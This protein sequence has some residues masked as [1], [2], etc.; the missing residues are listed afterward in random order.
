[1]LTHYPV[2]WR[3]K[4]HYFV[5]FS[6]LLGNVL[7]FV[8]GC[9]A[10]TSKNT[11]SADEMQVLHYIA[12]VFIFFLCL[13]WLFS[14]FRLKLNHPNFKD[15]LTTF[16]A[17]GLCMA[18]VFSNVYV[19][20]KTVVHQTARLV[21]VEQLEIDKIQIE[22]NAP[23]ET[24]ATLKRYGLDFAYNYAVNIDKKAL[25]LK[26]IKDIEEAHEYVYATGR[27]RD[28]YRTGDWG[29]LLLQLRRSAFYFLVIL[30]VFLFMSPYMSVRMFLSVAFCHLLLHFMSLI[31]SR[32]SHYDTDWYVYLYNLIFEG[33]FL[34]LVIG[35]LFI[36][37]NT[38]FRR[39][40]T[41]LALPLVPL[42]ASGLINK[43][44][45]SLNVNLSGSIW[46]PF[47]IMTYL[48][49]ISWCALVW[50]RKNAEPAR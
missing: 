31:F 47:F 33:T 16:F 22:E 10:I 36:R 35:I 14:Q 11:I 4:V 18:A 27:T 39:F 48:V 3:T 30:P 2:L 19:F 37:K 7:A 46:F 41:Y 45:Y 49:I 32:A 24:V 13:F 5:I 23:R 34:L 8:V 40:L 28:Y 17:Y 42:V 26:I 12:Q 6:L 29:I 44:F 43:L 20:S 9:L 38:G 21:S 1:M 25:V 50:V 15:L